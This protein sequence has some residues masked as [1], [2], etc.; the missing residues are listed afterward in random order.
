MLKINKILYPTDFSNAASHA[1]PFAVGLA[2]Q[3]DAELHMLHALVLHADDPGN[4][5]H[6]FP[7]IEEL[8]KSM[9]E[10]A[11]ERLGAAAEEHASD[12]LE[13]HQHQERGIAAP[14]VILDYVEEQDIDLVVMG[15]HGRRGLRRMLLGSVAEEVV[16]L[17]P[18]PVL[19]VRE[20]AEMQATAK[21]DNLIVPIDF[22]EHSKLALSYAA[23][24]ARP[25]GAKIQLLHV[26][27]ETVYPDFYL[28]VLPSGDIVTEKLVSQANQRL[29]QLAADVADGVESE[30]FVK[31]GRAAHE[32]ADFV[33]E[34]D[35]E[36]VVIASH[37]LTGLSHVLLGSV[38]ESVVRRADC[39][40]FTVK[41]FG[42][43][44]AA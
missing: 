27:E 34:Q 21:I 31:T 11:Q 36:M 39:P 2:E 4:V 16:R 33:K 10:S 38:T 18:C 37:G 44:L 20:R 41:A 5:A 23:E 35:A 1:L 29:E 42:K 26:V 28:P 43:K 30:A 13:V 32:I 17:A 3:F 40:V 22:S 9:H 12:G 7:N 6:R 8:Y 25:H 14:G 19:T 24:L 15:T